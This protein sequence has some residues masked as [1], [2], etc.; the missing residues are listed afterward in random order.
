[1]INQSPILITG[2]PRSGTAMVAGIFH[3]CGVF[4]GV[5]DKMYENIRVRDY[6]VK[7][8]L[9][10]IDMDP[11]GCYPILNWYPMCFPDY[12]NEK[13]SEEFISQGLNQERWMYK[14]CRTTLLWM[15]WELSFP[16]AAWVIVRRKSE[17]IIES[18]KKTGYM[19]TFSEK[20]T[21]APLGVQSVESAWKWVVNEY[22]IRFDKITNQVKTQFTVWPE[23]MAQGNFDEIKNVVLGLGLEWRE[24]EV[25]EY[26]QPRLYKHKQKEEI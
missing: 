5:T 10:K 23:K 4:S 2:C 24:K 11:N 20:G 21:Y 17:D 26:I 8:Y 13:I 18:C 15:L 6:L 1:M 25:H 7:N 22:I 12:W 9:R 16:E 3:I 19:R 14:D